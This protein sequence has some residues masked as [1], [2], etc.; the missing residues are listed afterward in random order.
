MFELLVCDP[1]LRPRPRANEFSLLSKGVKL[2][3]SEGKKVRIT[4]KW[5]K[6]RDLVVRFV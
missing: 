5:I 6:L 1:S 3:P 4:H 2:E